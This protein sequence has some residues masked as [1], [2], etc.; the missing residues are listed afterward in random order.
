MTTQSRL[1]QAELP[2]GAI[3][4][5]GWLQDQLRLQA[6]GLTGRL[7]EVWPDVGPGSGW[8]GG[9]G[10]S[11][12]RGPYYLD[13]L[14]PLAHILDDQ[15]LIERVQPWIEAM[16]DSQRPDGWFGPAGNDDWWPRMVACKVLCQHHDASG[17]RRVI[18]VL[19]RYFDY[20]LTHLP[21]RPLSGWG[22][23]RG[24]DNV[25]SVLWLHRL[26]GSE[27]LLE[28]ADLL[29]EQTEDWGRYLTTELV[30]G[31]ALFFDHRTHGV[32]VAMG[33]KTDAVRYLRTG[34]DRFRQR[35]DDALAALERWHGLAHGCFSGDEFL[36]GREATAGVETCLVVELMYTYEQL[37]RIF[38]DSAWADRLE[39]L[40]FNLLPASCDPRMLAHQ[41]HQQANQVRVSVGQRPWTYSSDDANIFGLEPHFGCCTANLHQGWPKLARTLWMHILDDDGDP[42]GLSVNSYPACT[43]R[44]T[45]AGTDVR[46]R[47]RGDYPF[48]SKIR[49]E[50]D[51]DRSA[52]FPVR[53]RIPGWCDE[54][55]L[56]VGGEFVPIAPG[57]DRVVLERRWEAGTVIELELPMVPRLERRERQAVAVRYGPLIMV[58]GV[59]E[60]WVPVPDAPG[61]GE[62]EVHPRSSWNHGIV[63][64]DPQQWS[65]T[66]HPVS[67]V[68]FDPAEPPV[69]IRVPGAR[70]PGW[71]L[72]GEQSAP[73]PEGP[74]LGCPVS[75]E[76]S[77]TPYGSSRLRL[78][79]IPTVS[80]PRHGA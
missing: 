16:I 71:G 29:L 8:L 68:P 3:R 38:D 57:A 56:S 30:T 2:V 10:E 43:V 70:I 50:I 39:T 41:Y 48:D 4:P 5:D 52:E 73:P 72:A 33:L 58:A 25:L 64:D 24:A 55:Q 40:A 11:W 36:G 47:V 80:A 44:T 26:T 32:N 69:R 67:P 75:H 7:P 77:L 37:L 23:V 63:P 1:R 34:D 6:D 61:L 31:R 42:V 19:T 27:R 20:Q 65:V 9:D 60:N 79:E 66:Q 28:L 74:V 12:E 59:A 14:L 45:L 17:D 78:T 15:E 22:R 18:D 35:T 76:V 53:L 54:P 21:G 46:L 62:W 51:G 13:G 49:I